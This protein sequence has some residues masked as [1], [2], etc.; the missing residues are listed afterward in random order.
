MTEN[1][2]GWVYMRK[3]PSELSPIKTAATQLL[4]QFEE[5]C[6]DLDQPK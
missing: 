2:I 6:F 5:I 1:V 4:K 3:M